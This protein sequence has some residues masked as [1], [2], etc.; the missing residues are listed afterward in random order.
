VRRKRAAI[1]PEALAEADAAVEWYR[2]RDARVAHRFLDKLER[3]IL[4]IEA[5]PKRFASRG[6][7]CRAAVMARFPY[8]VVFWES[9]EGI[10]IVA[11]AH[12]RRRPGYWVN[13]L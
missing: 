11:V 5:N 6:F 12:G 4:Q 1:H 2:E 7:G 13:R 10:E 9:D 8:Q 3:L